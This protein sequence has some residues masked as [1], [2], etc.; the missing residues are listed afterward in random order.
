MAAPSPGRSMYQRF[1]ILSIN[2][3]G[4]R[5]FGFSDNSD[6]VS[7]ITPSQIGIG[8]AVTTIGGPGVLDRP[9]AAFFSSDD[10]TAYVV[11]CGAECGGNAGQFAAVGS[12]EDSACLWLR[13]FPFV[14]PA[15]PSVAPA[16]PC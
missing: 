8:N 3:S 11:S 4:N 12:D 5:I 7:V 16:K 13:L 1:T 10:N 2:H 14:F 15:Q 6:F 9:V